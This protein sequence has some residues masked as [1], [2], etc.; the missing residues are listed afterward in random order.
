MLAA[1]KGQDKTV[2]L[3]LAEGAAAGV[4]GS[5]GDTAADLAEKSGYPDLARRLRASS[6]R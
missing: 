3:L 4:R 2:E 1:M 5:D 6:G